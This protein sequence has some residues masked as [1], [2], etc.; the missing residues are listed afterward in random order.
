MSTKTVLAVAAAVIIVILAAGAIVASNG[1]N[2]SISGTYELNECSQVVLTKDG[3]TT[4]EYE[5]DKIVIKS[6]GNG[7]V[8]TVWEGFESVGV[9]D[10]KVIRFASSW[11]YEGTK[12]L[13]EGFGVVKDNVYY[14]T[15]LYESEDGSYVIACY[16]TFVKEG[17]KAEVPKATPLLQKDQVFT[18]YNRVISMD[19][20]SFVSKAPYTMEVIDTIGP[21][22]VLEHKMTTSHNTMYTYKTLGIRTG[23]NTMESGSEMYTG[24]ST[25]ITDGEVAQIDYSYVHAGHYITEKIDMTSSEKTRE[26]VPSTELNGKVYVGTMSEM[27]TDGKIENYDASFSFGDDGKGVFAVYANDSSGY[28]IFT[29]ITPDEIG[30]GYFV[31]FNDTYESGNLDAYDI[32]RGYIS[33]DL[34]TLSLTYVTYYSDGSAGITGCVTK[35][36]E[37]NSILGTYNAIHADYVYGT[38]ATSEDFEAPY[39]YKLEIKAVN[40][41]AVIGTIMGQAFVGTY[42]NGILK[43]MWSGKY[44]SEEFM[45]YVSVEFLDGV[46]LVRNIGTAGLSSYSGCYECVKE[47]ASKVEEIPASVQYYKVGDTVTAFN[48]VA[49]YNGEDFEFPI[50]QKL[51]CVYSDNGLYA[52]EFTYSG[53]ETSILNGYSASLG[54]VRASGI[55]NGSMATL[56]IQNHDNGLTCVSRDAFIDGCTMAYAIRMSP[57]GKAIDI[58]TYQDLSGKN[59]LGSTYSAV[60][61]DGEL[62]VYDWMDYSS[63]TLLSFQKNNGSVFSVSISGQTVDAHMLR[64]ADGTPYKFEFYVEL[65]DDGVMY[66]IEGYGVF[67]DGGKAL[68]LYCYGEGDDG[69]SVAIVSDLVYIVDTKF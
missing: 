66:Y 64:N 5:G 28:M 34:S 7:F 33:S 2:D 44:M 68:N 38:E 26:Y 18:S 54:M 1:G 65:S 27:G 32:A 16:A 57:D 11:E 62:E 48:S 45:E 40:E 3:Y 43:F 12:Y 19:T 36:T 67:S 39:E 23:P 63:G 25:I 4:L 49:K 8:K 56:T 14:Y 35:L 58:P 30:K 21:I 22:S 50:G 52:F 61:K 42:C 6:L 51:K 17:T 13:E 20:D 69:S 29:S 46:C 31:T 10:G 59:Y 9:S 55:I 24:Y 37:K 60:L 41:D 53:G 47:G 15:S